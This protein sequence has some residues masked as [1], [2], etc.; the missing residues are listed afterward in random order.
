[1]RMMMMMRRSWASKANWH[2]LPSWLLLF[3]EITPRRTPSN[4]IQ[5]YMIKYVFLVA[6][7]CVIFQT[8]LPSEL[9]SA[10]FTMISDPKVFRPCVVFQRI[11][12][13]VCFF[14]VRTRVPYFISFAHFLALSF[15]E[16]QTMLPLEFF[17]TVLASQL[18]SK[19]LCHRVFLQG[20]PLPELFLTLMTWVKSH[21][22]VFTF[23]VAFSYV[24]AQPILPWELFFTMFAAKFHT[25]VFCHPVFLQWRPVYELFST[26]QARIYDSFVLTLIMVS[27]L[28][29]IK[30]YIVT[31]LAWEWNS[32]VFSQLV[33]SQV[34]FSSEF[35]L[36]YITFVPESFVLC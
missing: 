4:A 1:M 27:K 3:Y 33:V 21:F 34:R 5:Q 10:I 16:I 13:S 26:V 7:S 19:M 20:W 9:L 14:A 31:L 6:S 29:D 11:L 15:V 8:R 32:L 17:F 12:E 23:F 30:R 25:K 2:N 24:D 28:M 36:A 18:H 22:N 35:C